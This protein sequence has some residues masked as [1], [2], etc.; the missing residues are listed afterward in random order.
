MLK[1]SIVLVILEPNFALDEWNPFCLARTVAAKERQVYVL[2][3]QRT[4]NTIKS[5]VKHR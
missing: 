2:Q 4:G 5:L 3:R 1:Y